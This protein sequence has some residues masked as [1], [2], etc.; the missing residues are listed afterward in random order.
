MG[1]MGRKSIIILHD[2]LDLLDQQQ[3]KFLEVQIIQ[4]ICDIG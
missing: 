2:I 3:K 1:N 4:D